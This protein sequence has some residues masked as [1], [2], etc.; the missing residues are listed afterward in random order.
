MCLKIF[1]AVTVVYDCCCG[2][3]GYSLREVLVLSRSSSVADGQ[4]GDSGETIS[5]HAISADFCCCCNGDAC[6]GRG[7][8][9]SSEMFSG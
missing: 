2:D 1:I 8:I 9:C 4:I 5:T 6:Y 3:T 7:N